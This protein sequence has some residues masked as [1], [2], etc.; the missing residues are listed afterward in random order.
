EQESARGSRQGET[1]G[2]FIVLSGFATT[3]LSVRFRDACQGGGAYGKTAA[4]RPFPAM[5]VI[6]H[7]FALIRVQLTPAAAERQE[8]KRPSERGGAISPAPTRRTPDALMW[9]IVP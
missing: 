6:P 1:P 8:R 5:F 4:P 9:H 7:A 2:I 3:D